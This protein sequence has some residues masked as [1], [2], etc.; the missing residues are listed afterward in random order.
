MAERRKFWQLKFAINFLNWAIGVVTAFTLVSFFVL[1]RTVQS[2]ELPARWQTN[3]IVFQL[4]FSGGIILIFILTIYIILHRAL[5]PLPRIERLLDKVL[6]GD[7][8]QRLIVR[9]KDFMYSFVTKVNKAIE[10]LD[11]KA[12]G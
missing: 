6:A 11:K 7:N 3:F 12:K 5:G 4:V 10:L 8:S 9:E 1:I 2:L